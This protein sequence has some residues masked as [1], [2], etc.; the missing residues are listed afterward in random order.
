MS[1]AAT[2][3]D[4][5]VVTAL[6][7]AADALFFEH[8]I[9]GV[10]MAQIRDRAGVSL[11]RLYATCPSKADLVTRWLRYRHI[12]WTKS[13][14]S[15]VDAGLG[16]G[17]DPVDA[18]FDALGQWMTDTEFRGCGFINTHA[19][20]AELNDEQRDIIRGHK[21]D[22]ATYLDDV[23]THGSAVAVLIDGAIVQASIFKSPEPI[24]H[25]RTAATALVK[26]QN[27]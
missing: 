19:E 26:G 11:R 9:V 13:F 3:C 15:A 2:M 17:N 16:D 18:V 24:N 14:S 7:Q 23:T 10:S 20:V 1:P 22:L 27:S 25:A 8:G 6:E 4:A 21:R 5:D 12:E